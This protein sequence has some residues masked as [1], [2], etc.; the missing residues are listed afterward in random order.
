MDLLER[1]GLDK[2]YYHR[3]PHQFS[4]GQRQRIGIARALALDPEIIVADEPV[5]ALDVSVQ[6]QIINLFKDLQDEFGFTYVFIAHDL[7]VVKYLSDRIA[8]M[9][10]GE[11]VEICKKEELFSNPLHPYTQALIS[12]IPIP[13]PRHKEE[14]IILKGDI[15][16][17]VNPPKGCRFHNRC[18][19]CMKICKKLQPKVKEINGHKVKC[20]L[21]MMKEGR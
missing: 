10:L 1:V 11:I 7:S 20:H 2:E 5:S 17:P 12:A 19:K 21:Y 3:F 13:N 18:F 4:G 16:S 14:R 9:Y 15:P 6:A 8:V